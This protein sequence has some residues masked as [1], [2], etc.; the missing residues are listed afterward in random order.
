MLSIKAARTPFRIAVFRITVFRIAVFGIMASGIIDTATA[1]AAV[2]TFVVTA[3]SFVP[4]MYRDFVV[5]TVAVITSAPGK[6]PMIAATVIVVSN[7]VS[8]TLIYVPVIMTIC[9]A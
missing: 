5:D 3:I 2:L 7:S 4:T 1:V 8:A 9:W 6:T